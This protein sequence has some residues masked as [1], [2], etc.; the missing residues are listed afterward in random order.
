MFLLPPL[1]FLQLTLYGLRQGRGR[2]DIEGYPVREG[3]Q[4]RSV[5]PE[6]RHIWSAPLSR[7][8]E[9]HTSL[10]D[11]LRAERPSGFWDATDMRDGGGR[12]GRWMERGDAMSV[13]RRE[14]EVP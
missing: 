8:G 7:V 3:S 1:Q 14:E 12:G 11:S 6:R 2:G 13:H 10:M 5:R 9:R 4:E